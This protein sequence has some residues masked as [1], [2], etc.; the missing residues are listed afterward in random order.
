MHQW[1]HRILKDEEELT[2]FW[3]DQEVNNAFYVETLGLL[4]YPLMKRI[5]TL[6]SKLESIDQSIVHIHE[7][8]EIKLDCIQ[9]HV[10]TYSTY[11]NIL[12]VGASCG[13]YV[14]AL[15]GMNLDIFDD[16]DNPVK[17]SFVDVTV[18]TSFIIVTVCFTWMIFVRYTRT[19]INSDAMSIEDLMDGLLKS[20]AKRVD[21]Y[22]STAETITSWGGIPDSP[23]V[24]R[25][26][27][28]QNMQVFPMQSQAL[29]TD[30]FILE[31]AIIEE[32]AVNSRSSTAVPRADAI[33]DTMLDSGKYAS[34]DMEKVELHLTVEGFVRYLHREVLHST[35]VEEEAHD[36]LRC[37]C[38]ILVCFTLTNMILQP[39]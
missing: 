4:F 3:L 2:D 38:A 14:T 16:P 11:I 31:I 27:V 20:V 36:A 25:K 18:V 32:A 5:N 30:P 24:S 17:N 23:D 19:N 21:R 28:S 8:T 9:N 39:S 29:A 26:R 15:Y 37:R 35:P 6:I 34:S 12:M 22:N 7:S 13:V 33:L 1:L 10:Y